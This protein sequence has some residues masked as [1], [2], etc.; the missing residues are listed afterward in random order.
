MGEWEESGRLR[1]KAEG[2]L[3]EKS[4]FVKRKVSFSG[5]E[6]MIIWTVNWRMRVNER[7]K[8][9]SGGYSS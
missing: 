2:I 4:D 5:K 1:G 9:V 7:G 3:R 8:E 6:L